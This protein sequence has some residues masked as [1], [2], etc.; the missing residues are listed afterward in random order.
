MTSFL[1]ILYKYKKK[2]CNTNLVTINLV[3]V[4]FSEVILIDDCCC[5]PSTQGYPEQRLCILMLKSQVLYGVLV[6][7]YWHIL[8][9]FFTRNSSLWINLD[10]Y[11]HPYNKIDN[12][13]G[14]IT[15]CTCTRLKLINLIFRYKIMYMM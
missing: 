15:H 11:C 7:S 5:Y 3:Y 14:L 8:S 9:S 6:F 1:K 10:N 2:K 4:S 13:R 12:Y